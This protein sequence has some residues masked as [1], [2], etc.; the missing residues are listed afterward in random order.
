VETSPSAFII[1]EQIFN[2]NSIVA[3]ALEQLNNAKVPVSG[4]D[5][6]FARSIFVSKL[7]DV[8]RLLSRG[9]QQLID[10]DQQNI[11][12]YTIFDSSTYNNVPEDLVLEFFIQSGKL[13]ANVYV[14]V[15]ATHQ[16][17]SHVR[18][19]STVSQPST[20]GTGTNQVS[21]SYYFYNGCP[22]E[23]MFHSRL[24]ATLP[25]AITALTSIENAL[26]LLDDLYQ[27][28]DCIQKLLD[29]C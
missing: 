21:S 18:Q 22:I 19:K 6:C 23:I 14:I 28:I 20:A 5:D 4:T 11:F 29:S 8:K 9:I 17:P 25:S 13:C 10:I 1:L 12:P 3:L 26:G 27:K 2:A 24:E 16:S 7:N 15:S